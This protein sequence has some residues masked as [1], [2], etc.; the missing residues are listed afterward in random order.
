MQI[1]SYMYVWHTW[2][3]AF[4]HIHMPPNTNSILHKKPERDTKMS[5]DRELVTCNVDVRVCARVCECLAC[6]CAYVCLCV[7]KRKRRTDET[8][9][10]V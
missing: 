1:N 10:T 7:F 5:R 9:E 6:V 3:E 2:C 4:A 8:R